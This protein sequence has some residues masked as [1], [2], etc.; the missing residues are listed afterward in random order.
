[1]GCIVSNN[2]TV[3]LMYPIC[4]TMA[5]NVEGVNLRQLLTVLM[6]GASSSFLTPVSCQVYGISIVFNGGNTIE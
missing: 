4:V 6:V 3:V 1:M 5:E 2:T